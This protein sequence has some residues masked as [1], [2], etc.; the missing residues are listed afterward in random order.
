[1]TPDEFDPN[2]T[3]DLVFPIAPHEFIAGRERVRPKRG[4]RATTSSP[5]TSVVSL[6]P[7]GSGRLRSAISVGILAGLGGVATRVA[8]QHLFPHLVVLIGGSGV[9]LA[10]AFVEAAIATGVFLAGARRAT[11][12]LVVALVALFDLASTPLVVAACL[13]ATRW[14]SP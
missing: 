5:V 3:I 7:V 2:A 4:H 13:L 1:M 10:L 9:L 8:V 14:P 12:I 6:D 11:I